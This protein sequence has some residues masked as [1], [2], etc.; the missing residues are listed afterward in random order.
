MNQCPVCKEIHSTGHPPRN[1]ALKNL[2][3]AFIQERQR[4]SKRKRTSS[5]SEDLCSLHAE[6]LKLFCL[7]CQQPACLV[8]RDSK[9]HTNHSF[10]PIDEAALDHKKDAQKSLERL[11][12][13]L[14]V[15]DEVKTNSDLTAQYIKVQARRTKRQIKDQF[16]KMH[17]FLRKEEKARITALREEEQQKSQMMKE[18]IEGLNRDI[19]TLSNNIRAIEEEL[20]ADHIS[21]LQN[22]KTTMQRVQFTLQDPQPV[23]EALIDE[24]KHLSNL[25]FRV[26]ERMMDIVSYTPV[27]LDPNTA[28]PAYILSDDLSSMRRRG[29]HELEN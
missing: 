2:C 4:A 8:C 9:K 26:W 28:H 24:A 1:L 22:Y 6:K 3:E 17:Q 16:K 10:R 18:K 23:S 21:F 12:E 5:G 14:K 15:F 29:N 25:I 27:I 19:S 13:K 20:K 7:E 11:Q